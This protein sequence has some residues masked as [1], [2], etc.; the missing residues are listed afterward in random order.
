MKLP[1]LI[2][3]RCGNHCEA[4]IEEYNGFS[5]DPYSP[6]SIEAAFDKIITNKAKWQQMGESSYKNALDCFNPDN[7]LADMI[8]FFTV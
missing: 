4:L 8:D 6:K 1:L 2:S 7:V 5:F 3:E